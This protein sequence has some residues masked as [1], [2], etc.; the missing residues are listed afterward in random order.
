M[1]III[2][3]LTL[4]SLNLFAAKSSISGPVIVGNGDNGEDLQSFELITEGP[5][6]D[7]RKKA[8]ELLR[9]FKVNR[10]EGLGSLI[11]E[12]ETTKLYMTKK[13]IS[14]Q[15]LAELGA[16]TT[17]STGLIYA[18]TMPEPYAVT[19]F[20]PASMSLT[21][22]QLIALHIHEGLHRSLPKSI[23]EDEAI[24]SS[25]TQMITEPNTSFDKIANITKSHMPR[26]Q[27]NMMVTSEQTTSYR[28]ITVS[29]R[30][31][32][33][34]PSKFSIESR[35]YNNERSE[36]DE[37]QDFTVTNMYLLRSHLY[38]FGENEDAIG[39]GIDASVIQTEEDSFM[40]PLSISARSLLYTRRN[41]DIEVFGQVN[42]NT[43]S[44]EELKNSLYGRDT[45]KLGI[46]LSTRRENFYI[47]NDLTYTL[48]SSIDQKLNDQFITHEFGAI[49]GVKLDAGFTYKKLNLG[50]FFEVLL[51]DNYK[52]SNQFGTFTE[53]T[54]RN[55]IVSIGPKLEYRDK[56]YAL[57]V[58]G[59]F[60]IDSTK[61]TSYEFLSDLMGYGVGQ[62]SINTA[63]NIYF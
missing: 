2:S 36:E 46:S 14:T 44:N 43:L 10:I 41:F 24:A 47:R 17:D 49:T 11:P 16:F 21:E 1:K 19:R 51:S 57:E 9:K 55:R 13:G 3:I 28:P 56:D 63:V 12:V 34:N 39:L 62:G 5:I 23:R 42:L 45:Y 53:Q 37:V 50:G 61:E 27:E 30:S 54:G 20:F 31:R 6:V 60:L 59:R 25:I 52:V 7:S 15:K 48:A 32:L 33:K 22:E 26:N 35:F 29:E 38:P 40:G 4:A 18:R 8:V 58:N